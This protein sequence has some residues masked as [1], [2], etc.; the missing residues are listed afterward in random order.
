MQHLQEID[1]EKDNNFNKSNNNLYLASLTSLRSLMS[2]F[3]MLETL[4]L[5]IHT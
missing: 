3:T 2:M 5:P 4:R 1:K